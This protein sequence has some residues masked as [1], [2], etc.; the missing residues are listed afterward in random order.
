MVLGDIVLSLCQELSGKVLGV[1]WKIAAL[2]EIQRRTNFHQG[3]TPVIA[4]GLGLLLPGSHC[5]RGIVA[6]AQKL[7]FKD[8][9]LQQAP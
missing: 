9:L 5:I 6:M 1:Q 4:C 8:P 7:R 2:R 3:G